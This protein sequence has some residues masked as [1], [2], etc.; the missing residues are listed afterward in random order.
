MNKKYIP[1]TGSLIP[2]V[3]SYNDCFQLIKSDYYRHYGRVDSIWRMFRAMYVN[4]GFRYTFWM[5]LCSYRGWLYP[6]T[7]YK[8][9]RVSKMSGIII[10]S[11]QLIGWGF[12]LGHGVATITNESAI[13]G[14]NCNLSHLTT[15]G[16]N[17]N[18]GAIIGDE[19]YI[20]PNVCVVEHVII[21]HGSVVGAGAVVVKDVPTNITVGGVPARQISNNGSSSFIQNKWDIK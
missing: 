13:I 12:Y 9:I 8:Q 21:G 11:T 17:K 5:R 15:I 16:T 6:L 19:V 1:E 18:D 14:N 2:V 7:R 4:V 10:P 3:E 20:G